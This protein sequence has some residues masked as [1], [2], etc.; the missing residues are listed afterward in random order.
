LKGVLS[1]MSIAQKLTTDSEHHRT[2]TKHERGERRLAGRVSLRGEA[3]QELPVGHAGDRAARE[4]RF[5]LP[6]D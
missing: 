5:D 3:A 2:V 6:H 4:E 1:L